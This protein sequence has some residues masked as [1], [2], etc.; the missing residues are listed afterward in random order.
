MLDDETELSTRLE[1]TQE[2]PRQHV[3]QQRQKSTLETDSGMEMG[4][5]EAGDYNWRQTMRSS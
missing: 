5:E 1:D 4:I 3:D 2:A